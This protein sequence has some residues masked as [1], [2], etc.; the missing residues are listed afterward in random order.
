MWEVIYFLGG[1]AVES[2]LY[3]LT[4]TEVIQK[5]NQEIEKHAILHTDGK[6]DY[7]ATYVI[8]KP[9]MDRLTVV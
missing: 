1:E 2:I 7:Q 4:L 3:D 5:A 6:V 9:T 8:G